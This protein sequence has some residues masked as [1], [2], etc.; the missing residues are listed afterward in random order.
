MCQ[1]LST[2]AADAAADAAVWSRPNV[3]PHSTGSDPSLSAMRPTESC[4]AALAKNV[5]ANAV[6]SLHKTP[7]I[8]C[9]RRKSSRTPHRRIAIVRTIKLAI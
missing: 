5:R 7:A 6:C 1:L 3:S 9:D 4:A 2:C 8:R